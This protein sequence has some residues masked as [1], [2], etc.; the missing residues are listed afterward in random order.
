MK[1]GTSRRSA[2][3]CSAVLLA[4]GLGVAAGCSSAFERSFNAGRYDEVVRQFVA[5][6]ALH[7]DPDAL[8]RAALAYATPDHPEYDVE[9]AR[10]LLG[11]LLERYPGRGHHREAVAL[12]SLLENASRLE[13]DG[14]R[15]ESELTALRDRIA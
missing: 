13:R 1:K 9:R 6:S 12:F 5:D 4:A 14:A 10:E 15:V 8:Y 2:R 11:E 3:I 7:S